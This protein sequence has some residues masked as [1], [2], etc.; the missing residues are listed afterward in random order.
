MQFDL[1]GVTGYTG[2]FLIQTQ[3]SNAVDHNLILLVPEPSSRFTLLHQ[4]TVA[5]FLDN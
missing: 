5:L 1:P 3:F 4:H 2:Q